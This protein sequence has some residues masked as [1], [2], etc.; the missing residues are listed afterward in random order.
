MYQSCSF[1]S[2]HTT[3]TCPKP[4]YRPQSMLFQYGYH[5]YL[6][7]DGIIQQKSTGGITASGGRCDKARVHSLLGF[8]R[9]ELVGSTSNEPRPRELGNKKC[10]CSQQCALWDIWMRETHQVP[11]NIPI[12][13]KNDD[14]WWDFGILWAVVHHFF[15]TTTCEYGDQQLE[16]SMCQQMTRPWS[17]TAIYNY[18]FNVSKCLGSFVLPYPCGSLWLLVALKITTIS[19]N[20]RFGT[21]VDHFLTLCGEHW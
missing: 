2:P 1:P 21:S 14:Q 6:F 7:E 8:L 13:F 18:I 9:F 11:S 19:P 4:L 17:S 20:S 16:S 10:G 15:E 5:G 3:S 12:H